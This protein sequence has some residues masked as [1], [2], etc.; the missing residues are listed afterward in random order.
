MEP[1]DVNDSTTI[2]VQGNTGEYTVTLGDA[3]RCSCPDFTFRGIAKDG[4]LTG[5]L[6]RHIRGVVQVAA[7]SPAPKDEPAALKAA[8]VKAADVILEAIEACRA[9]KKGKAEAAIASVF[10]RLTPGQKGAVTR[11]LNATRF[12]S[13]G[14]QCKLP[15]VEAFIR[16]CVTGSQIGHPDLARAEIMAAHIARESAPYLPASI[17]EPPHPFYNAHTLTKMLQEQVKHLSFVAASRFIAK[18]IPALFCPDD[19]PETDPTPDGPAAVELPAP[20]LPVLAPISGGSPESSASPGLVDNQGMGTTIEQGS[21]KLTVAE[22]KRRLKVGM[23]L[24]HVTDYRGNA[25]DEVFTI[26]HIRTVDVIFSELDGEPRKSYLAWPKASELRATAKGWEIVRGGKV[27]FGVEWIEDATPVNDEAAEGPTT[28]YSVFEVL[29]ATTRALWTQMKSLPFLM[30]NDWN[31]SPNTFRVILEGKVLGVVQYAGGRKL[32]C[33]EAEPV[34]AFPA[35][36]RGGVLAVIQRA[37]DELFYDRN[38]NRPARGLRQYWLGEL[39]YA[40]RAGLL[41]WLDEAEHG[42]NDGGESGFARFKAFVEGCEDGAPVTFDGPHDDGPDGYPAP[43]PRASSAHREPATPDFENHT[44]ADAAPAPG[45]PTPSDTPRGFF[46]KKLEVPPGP[47]SISP[48]PFNRAAD[49]FADADKMMDKVSPVEENPSRSTPVHLEPAAMDRPS[50]PTLCRWCG[51][52]PA[53][54]AVWELCATCCATL[55]EP[56]P[57]P[58]PRRRRPPMSAASQLAAHGLMPVSGGA[59]DEASPGPWEMEFVDARESDGGPH[60]T[61]EAPMLGR[62]GVIADTLN[63]DYTICQDEARANARILGAAWDGL[64]FAKDHDAAMLRIGYTGPDDPILLPG[65]AQHWRKCRAFIAKA[66]GP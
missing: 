41:A 25:C 66:T 64:E 29:P 65:D 39:S 31:G 33:W 43:G 14:P 37:S 40:E 57:Q 1:S 6:C 19:E 53:I 4:G 63:C 24:R 38:N 30:L 28:I 58:A 15:S 47:E 52:Q 7:C 61:I 34:P 60:Y 45:T 23:K 56:D 50:A 49:H 51:R 27:C 10:A 21:A 46:E 35:M 32:S 42:I 22:L 62:H 9:A 3:P 13:F 20:N 17:F 26:G 2:Q 12:P 55:P 54:D 59:P 18:H 44:G 48:Q 11:L 8:P 16:S 36:K 5:H